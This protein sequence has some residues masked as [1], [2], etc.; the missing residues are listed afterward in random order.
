[1]I[2]I[3][4]PSTTP[5]SVA[6]TAALDFGTAT[7]TVP[8]LP[9][10]LRRTSHLDA[11]VGAGPG[12]GTELSG[13]A[14]DIHTDAHGAA[15]LVASASLRAH[16]HPDRSLQSLVTDP[17][18]DVDGL[19]GRAVGRGFRATL[20]T[21]VPVERTARSPLFL[22]LDELPVILVIS[23]YVDLFTERGTANPAVEHQ[24]DICSGFRHEG[25]MMQSFDTT[26]ALPISIG[27]AAGDLGADDDLAWHD[28]DDQVPGSMRR[29][30]LVEIRHDAAGHRSFY[31]Y[32][33]DTYRASWDEREIVMHEYQIHG[34]VD[35][36]LGHG[37]LVVRTCVAEPLTLPWPECPHAAASAGWIVG[38]RVDQIRDTVRFEYRGTDICTHLNDLVRSLGDLDALDATL[39]ERSTADTDGRSR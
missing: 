36:G 4:A 20:D 38:K 31:G 18:I 37:A 28:I 5:V 12:D 26:G 9:R 34:T 3:V 29:R 14:R 10:S 11:L 39:H 22:L 32:F 30:R 21:A 24:R 1:M 19:L 6:L 33:R 16:L 27:P 8:R 23:G 17:G 15:H 35:V 7:S 25:V 2:P 13:A